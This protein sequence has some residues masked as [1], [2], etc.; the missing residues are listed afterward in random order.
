MTRLIS[1][2]LLPMNKKLAAVSRPSKFTTCTSGKSGDHDLGPTGVTGFIFQCAE[3]KLNYGCYAKQ[4]VLA[5]NIFL[6][7]SKAQRNLILQI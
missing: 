2:I 7:G 6:G 3:Q 5:G 4:Q 1:E